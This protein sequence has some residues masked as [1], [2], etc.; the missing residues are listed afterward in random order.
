[1]NFCS[2]IFSE[3]HF[4]GSLALMQTVDPEA[5]MAHTLEVDAGVTPWAVGQT[6]VSILQNRPR[7]M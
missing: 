4:S 5:Q 1:M 7:S 6:F 2:E 3:A